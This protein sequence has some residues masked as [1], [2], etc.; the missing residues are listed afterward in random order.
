[1]VR[2]NDWGAIVRGV[3]AVIECRVTQAVEAGDH[4]VLIGEVI[5]AQSQAGKPLVYFD[6]NYR[7]IE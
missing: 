1:M 2:G 4:A 3:L 5:R 6:Q 7:A